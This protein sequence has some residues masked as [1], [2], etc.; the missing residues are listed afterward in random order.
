MLRVS[1][2]A[3]DSF[4]IEVRCIQQTL[5]LEPCPYHQKVGLT[6]SEKIGWFWRISPSIIPHLRVGPS[7]KTARNICALSVPLCCDMEDHQ[8]KHMAASVALWIRNCVRR[9]SSKHLVREITQKQVTPQ[10]VV[11]LEF[12]DRF[13]SFRKKVSRNNLITFILES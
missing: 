9:L 6:S 1:T 11:H 2:N 13:T 12:F 5:S 4:L 7:P 3:K 8:K 10:L